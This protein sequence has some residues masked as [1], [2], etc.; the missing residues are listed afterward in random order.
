MSIY[1]VTN[2]S[3]SEPYINDVNER[4]MPTFRVAKCEIDE[5]NK[6]VKYGLVPD[7]YAAGYQEIA[8]AAKS[9]DDAHLNGTAKMFFDLYN[10]MVKSKE[11]CDTLF[12]IHGFN[13]T[14][15]STLEHIYE[16]HELYIKPKNSP[17]EHLIYVSWPTVGNLFLTYWNDQEDAE[18][19]GR[20]L[21]RLFSKLFGFFIDAFEKAELER[22]KHKIHLAAHSMGN[23]VLK[24][25]LAGI[26]DSKLFP[27]FKEVLLLNADVE[28]DV[29]EPGQPFTKL[30]DISERVH[31]YIH[32]S[33]D[34]LRISRTTK[35]FKKRLG[36]NGPKNR[37]ILD[38]STFIMDTTYG[39]KPKN[40]K[41]K[42]I[43]HWGY[44]NRPDVVKDIKY[45]LTGM[46]EDDIPVR[47]KWD[48]SSLYFYFPK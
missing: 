45:V 26:P 14:F 21:S 42:W 10:Q 36:F 6:K 28:Y 3:I 38:A 41:E 2:R 4:A 22:C 5:E 35:N 20:V 24:H 12:F 48:E 47:E 27:L 30:G 18:E 44:L 46:D 39:E 7:N 13:Y 37:D 16:L 11:P 15:K 9:K 25:M 23:Q 32:N 40:K 31:M 29:F 1:I 33:D 17:I 19:T 34:A 8:S 43:D